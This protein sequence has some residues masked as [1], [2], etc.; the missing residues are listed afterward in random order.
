M[1]HS[2]WSCLCVLIHPSNGTSPGAVTRTDNTPEA[3]QQS[4]P[5]NL[6]LMVVLILKVTQPTRRRRCKDPNDG[7]EVGWRGGGRLNN[8]VR[9]LGTR[10][11]D[12]GPGGRLVELDKSRRRGRGRDH[13][14]RLTHQ[15]PAAHRERKT[16]QLSAVALGPPSVI[17]SRAGF[18]RRM[19]CC[20]GQPPPAGTPVAASQS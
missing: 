9:H 10:P 2:Q 14:R 19:R 11:N 8:P 17:H 1:L 15:C 6:A 4:A 18:C 12:S 20:E 3:R 7:R 16:P 5:R 13:P